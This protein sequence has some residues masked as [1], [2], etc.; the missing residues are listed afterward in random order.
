MEA[1]V[2]YA[3]RLASGY[4]GRPVSRVTPLGG[5]FYGRVYL[6]ECQAPPEKV[7][8]KLYLYPRLSRREAL[9]LETLRRHA[10][11]PMPKVL[12]LHDADGEVPVDALLMEHLPGVNA[13]ITRAKDAASRERIAS[14]VVEN[15]LAYHA[16]RHPEGFGE[17][18]DADFKA[19]WADF[20][21]PRA[22][23]I[24]QKARALHDAG[25][26]DAQALRVVDRAMN[27]FDRIFAQPVAPSLI[28]GDYNM[29]NVMLDERAERAT[30]VIDPFGCCWADPEMDLYQLE[31][32]NGPE[33]GL[34]NLYRRRVALS[35]LFEVKMRFYTL[36]T[37]LMHFHDANVSLKNSAVPAQADALLST[38]VSLGL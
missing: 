37:E 14:Q 6:A 36:F 9:Q 29:W 16:V 2:Q 33:Y 30:G 27:G 22:L 4:L 10:L 38:L 8:V 18:D 28:H 19:S 1:F 3:G 25:E 24:A 34:L 32:A 5:G 17:L 12:L 15:L 26:L 35:E 13:G 11:L 20:Y 23:S 7:V 21:R 31:N